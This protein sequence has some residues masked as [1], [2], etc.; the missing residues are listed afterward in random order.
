MATLDIDALVLADLRALSSI[1]PAVVY[2]DDEAPL[3]DQI[4]TVGGQVVAHVIF[5]SG[6]ATSS[7]NGRGIVGVQ[8][9]PIDNHFIVEVVAPNKAI[10]KMLGDRIVQHLLGKKFTG[11]T[12]L[13]LGPRSMYRSVSEESNIPNTYHYAALFRYITNL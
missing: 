6:M 9:D 12:A 13:E 10:A 2:D 1:S 8:L 7:G 5:H 4:P 3:E 11:A